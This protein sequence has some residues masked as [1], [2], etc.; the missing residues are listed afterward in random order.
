[1]QNTST[2]YMPTYLTLPINT[3]SQANLGC[4]EDILQSIHSHMSYMVSTHNKVLFVRFDLHFPLGFYPELT[5]A[6]LSNFI[7]L[8]KEYYT[9]HKVEMHYLWVREQSPGNPLPHYHFIALFDGNKLQSY[10]PIVLKADEFWQ[11]RVGSIPGLVNYCDK[12]IHGLPIK[13]GIMIRR[14]SSYAIGEELLSQQN[15]FHTDFCHCFHWASYLAKTNQ[16]QDT[17]TGSRRFGKSTPH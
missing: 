7:K 16:K 3:G 5:S 9:R 15:Q 8:F 6:A 1:M 11:R 13:N 4:Y 10:Y 12:N 14:P 17:P 2:T